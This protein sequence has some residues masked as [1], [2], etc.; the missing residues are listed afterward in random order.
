MPWERGE[1]I[2]P[3]NNNELDQL[4]YIVTHNKEYL[5]EL[6][7]KAAEETGISSLKISY[8]CFRLLY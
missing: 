8:K 2:A 7:Q 1:V 4:R 5:Q 3:G 6:Q